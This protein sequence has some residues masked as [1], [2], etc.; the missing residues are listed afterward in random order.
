MAKDLLNETVSIFVQISDENLHH[1]KELLEE[2]FGRENFVCQITF[3]K[4]N[5]ALGAKLI[6][7]VADY[8]VWYARDKK[9]ISIRIFLTSNLLTLNH[10]VLSGLKMRMVI[11]KSNA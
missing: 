2:V 1:V 7:Q 5:K 3:R 11:K 6:G 4:T 8:I 10:Q 9:I